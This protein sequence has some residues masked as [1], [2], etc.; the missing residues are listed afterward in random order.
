MVKPAL[1]LS[2]APPTSWVLK[3]LEAL[4]EQ[5]LRRAVVLSASERQAHAIRRHACVDSGRPGLL[6]GVLFVRP[7]EFARELLVRAGLVRLLG[8]QE[9]RRLRILHLFESESLAGQLRYFR[10]EQLRSGKGYG[11]AFARTIADLEASG[12][13]AALSTAVAQRLA[14]QDRRAADRLHDV[15]VTWEAA[16]TGSAT[17]RTT[18]QLLAEAAELIG[19]RPELPV[20]FG[21]IFAILTASP[22]TALLRFLRALPGCRILLQDARPL[23]SGT[24]RWRS[25]AA[26]QPKYEPRD[27]RTGELHFAVPELSLVQRF[28]FAL[29]EVL[30]DSRRPRSKGPDG[31]VDLEEYPSIEDE[32]EAAVGWV[33][34]QIHAGT[35]LEQVALLVPEVDSYAPLLADRLA[36]L[37]HDAVHGPVRTYVAGG[38]PLVSSAAGMRVQIVLHA[39]ARALEAGATIRVLPLLRRGESDSGQGHLRLSPSRAAEIVYGAGILGGTPGDPAGVAEWAPRL[40]RQREAQRALLQTRASADTRERADAERWLRDVEPILPAVG[41]LQALAQAVVDG[42]PLAGVWQALGDFCRKRL[43]VPPGSPDVLAILDRRLR[44]TLQ[45]PVSQAVT[46]FSAVRLLMDALRSERQPTARFG[47]PC[48]FIG[49]AAEAAGLSFAAVRVLGLVEGALPHVPH[50]DPIIPDGLRREIEVTAARLP[51]GADVVLPRLADRVLDDIHDVFRV[52]SGVRKRLALSA[53]R[54]WVDRSERE[55]SGIMLEVATA[56]GRSAAGSDEGDV[57]TAARLRAAYFNAGREARRRYAAQR[58]LS[59]RALFAAVQTSAAS[60]AEGAAPVP[61]DWLADGALDLEQVQRRLDAIKGDFL[62]GVDGIVTEG[63]TPLLQTGLAAQR[64]ISASALNMLLRCPHQFLLQR[65]LHLSPPTSP[66][67]TDTI[68]P[69]VYG[70]LFHAVAERFYGEAG[71]ALCRREGTLEQW[72]LRAC[73]IAAEDFATL[74]QQYAVRGEDGMSRERNRLLRQVEQLVIYEWNLPAREFLESEMT[75]GTPD[76]VCL[77]L[78][79]CELYVRGKVDRIDRLQTQLLAVK[80]LKT[81]RVRDFG[82][83]PI[84]AGR[85]LQIGLYVLALEAMGYGGVPVGLAGYVH[86]SA[87][88]EPDRAFEGANVE[89]L[90]RHTREWLG[91]AQMLLREGLFPRTPNADDCRNCPFVSACGSDAARRAAVKLNRLPPAHAL[92]PFARFKQRESELRKQ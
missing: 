18:P 21:P 76:P 77:P 86:P 92:E 25:A 73:A 49:T 90:R 22:S 62:D 72:V 35:R 69:A 61:A 12:M 40:S 63:W 46:G 30:T 80:D 19:Q 58:P 85:D 34:E 54:Q 59:P 82:E 2:F 70:G 67:S 17:T 55:V 81:G 39:L 79:G 9:V 51:G 57:P 53:P 33:T 6:N 8:W 48:L 91:I 23:R 41:E 84:N 74:C 65:V 89:V 13:D 88:R 31:S 16:D 24:Q 11:D 52:I 68:E 71:A 36:R 66:P 50:D 27:D 64:P 26:V 43:R 78:D 32:I 10:S 4:P 1:E 47:E 42:A 38:L 87:A 60:A 20:A 37:P 5:P 75:F 83:E 3:Q 45:D 29:P 14:L 15:A 56:L 7:V 44:P 28:L